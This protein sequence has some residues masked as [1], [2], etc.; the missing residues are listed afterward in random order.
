MQGS[1]HISRWVAITPALTT[2][3][4]CAEYPD[5]TRLSDSR[6]SRPWWS[7]CRS[8][9]MVTTGVVLKE[10]LT[11][12]TMKLSLPHSG[13]QLKT[14]IRYRGPI[15]RTSTIKCMSSLPPAY[16]EVAAAPGTVAFAASDLFTKHRKAHYADFV[17]PR[18]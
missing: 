18:L 15:E 13:R 14:L 5:L 11:V 8:S 4:S 9:Q 12:V 7:L 1:P 2:E 17:N 16:W 10:L 6:A 3:R